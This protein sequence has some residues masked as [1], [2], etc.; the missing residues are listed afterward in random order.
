M[1]RIEQEGVRVISQPG[2]L[3]GHRAVPASAAASELALIFINSRG[4]V[5]SLKSYGED[6]LEMG[7]LCF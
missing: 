1:H 3:D 2:L 6:M 7:K 5:P 4:K